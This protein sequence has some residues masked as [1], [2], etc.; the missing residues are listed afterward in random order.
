MGATNYQS[1]QEVIDAI[2]AM[3]EYPRWKEKTAYTETAEEVVDWAHRGVSE[4]YPG[5]LSWNTVARVA[6][7][8]V[9]KNELV[10][11]AMLAV[12]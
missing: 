12:C 6:K 4:Q 8:M 5:G 2:K 3:R 10:S 7:Y 9:R 11:R 1:K